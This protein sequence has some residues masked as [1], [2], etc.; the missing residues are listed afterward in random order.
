LHADVRVVAAT[1]RALEDEIKAGRFREDLYYRLNVLTIALPP[2]SERRQDIPELVE[3]F[4][5]TRQLGPVRYQVEP[6]ALQA[7]VRYD[8][9]GNVRELANVLERAQIL[10]EGHVITPDDLPE[11]LTARSSAGWAE[12]D[13]GSTQD[14]RALQRRHVLA[15]LREAR[16]NKV[17]AAKALGISRRALYRLLEKYQVHRPGEPGAPLATSPP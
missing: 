13:E 5:A 9:P 14:L 1:N 7:L 17:Q 16:G 15:V 12:Q 6:E 8:W 2:L 11:D 10:A 4:L 3:H